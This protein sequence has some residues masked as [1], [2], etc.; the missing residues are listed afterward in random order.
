MKG[1]AGD[2]VPNFLSQDNSFVMG[3]RQKPLTQKKIDMWINQ[4]PE[5]FCDETMLKN[6]QRNQLLIDL[7]FTPSDVKQKVIEQYGNEA[8]KTREHLFNYFVEKKLKH[9][10]ESISEF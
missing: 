5:E 1:D 7:S 3:I 10:L 8:G 9:L 4:K 2:G 6:Y